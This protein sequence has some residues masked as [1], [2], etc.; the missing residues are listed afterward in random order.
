M[1]DD[2]V[3]RQSFAFGRERFESQ[4]DRNQTVVFARIAI[5]WTSDFLLRAGRKLRVFYRPDGSRSVEVSQIWADQIAFAAPCFVLST[6]RCGTRWL[7]ELLRL[8]QYADVNHADYPELIR[9]SRLAYEQYEQMPR[10]FCEIIRATRDELVVD[11]YRHHQ[12][13]VETNNRITFFARAI[14]TVYPQARFIHLV[15]HPGDFVRSGMNRGWYR[16]H[17]HDIGRIVR[18]EEQKAWEAMS[19]PAKIAWLWNETNQ[20]VES[21]LRE[22]PAQDYVQIKSEDMFDDLNTVVDLIDFL[23]ITD[24][25]PAVVSCMM[26]RRINTQRDW[27]LPPYCTWSEEERE[28]VRRHATLATRYG[29]CLD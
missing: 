6:G 7:T 4:W 10:V 20:F 25:S 12:V 24:L 18:T 1:C 8:S 13:Y 23:G 19:Y 22:I 29:Y 27:S 21:F 2:H 14:K 17:P 26:K 11:A 9:H 5:Q 15:R 28:Q 16:G 3:L